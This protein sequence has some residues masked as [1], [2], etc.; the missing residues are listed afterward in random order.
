MAK[1][2]SPEANFAHRL[3]GTLWSRAVW[4]NGTLIECVNI[5]ADY[6]ASMSPRR[7]KIGRSFASAIR[8]N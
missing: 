1:Q 4:L 6:R 5:F 3:L 8:Y 7:D 2:S